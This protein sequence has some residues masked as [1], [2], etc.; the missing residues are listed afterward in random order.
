MRHYLLTALLAGAAA[1]ANVAEHSQRTQIA[2][3]DLITYHTD[4]KDVV[5]IQGTLPAGDAMAETGNIAI[6]TLAGMMLDR[7]TKTLDSLRLPSSWTTSVR[8]SLSAWAHRA[9]NSAPSP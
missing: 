2:G 6:P 8:R 5:V 7:G 3:I 1:Q 4:V 9:W